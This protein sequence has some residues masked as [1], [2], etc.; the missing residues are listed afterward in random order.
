MRSMVEGF[1]GW[2]QNRVFSTQPLHPSTTLPPVGAVYPERLRKQQPKGAVPLP[3]SGRF[4]K[5]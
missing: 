3:V 4:W 1:G 5:E 2:V